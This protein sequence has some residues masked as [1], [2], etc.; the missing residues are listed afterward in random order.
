MDYGVDISIF[1]LEMGKQA[2]ERLSN[3]SKGTWQ[4]GCHWEEMYS[5]FSL[6]KYLLP[7]SSVLVSDVPQGTDLTAKEREDLMET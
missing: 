7:A 6:T 3:L 5:L 1:I 2:S 4:R